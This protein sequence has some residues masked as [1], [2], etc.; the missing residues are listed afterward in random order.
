MKLV[1][2]SFYFSALP[3]RDLLRQIDYKTDDLDLQI[4]LGMITGSSF[5][6]F[7]AREKSHLTNSTKIDHQIRFS[8]ADRIKRGIAKIASDVQPRIPKQA[9]IAVSVEQDDFIS[10]EFFSRIPQAQISL[11]EKSNEGSE[12][13]SLEEQNIINILAEPEQNIEIILRKAQER[14]YTGDYRSAYKLLSAVKSI[15]ER[16]EVHY[17]LGLCTNFFGRTFESEEHFSKMLASSNPLSVVKASYVISMLYLRMHPREKQDLLRAEELLENAYHVLQMHPEVQD[18]T[19]HQVFNRNGFALCLFRRGKVEA[20]LN[21]LEEGILRL[22]QDDSG[23]KNLHQSV[24][25][26][27]AVQCLRALQR[28]QDC[29]VKCEELL[30]MDPLFPEYSLELARVLLDQ[31]KNTDALVILRKAESL[32]PF[33]P[34]TQ[35]L[36]A[37]ACLQEEDYNS[38]A[39]FYAKAAAIK[40]EEIQWKLDEAYCLSECGRW[41]ELE[42]LLGHLS[43]KNLLPAQRES[44]QALEQDLEMNREV[45]L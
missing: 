17:M 19:F 3:V 42:T 45:A 33:I 21:M 10:R 29:E 18:H 27:N 8:L 28:Y 16:D 40:P 30:A 23:A 31:K 12:L 1:S 34:E 9:V 32:D 5:E 26:Y 38:A 20:A 37:F 25:I 15:V 22:K 36:M 11:L 2:S 4:A 43:K 41:S 6:T 13:L 24:L 35:A 7:E 39:M 44:L 14:I